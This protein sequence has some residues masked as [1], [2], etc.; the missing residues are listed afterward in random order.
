VATRPSCT[1]VA[2]NLCT[3]GLRHAHGAC[4]VPLIGRRCAA[5]SCAR[6]SAAGPYVRL[7]E[8][9]RLGL[10]PPVLDRMFDPFL[11]HYRG[12]RGPAWVCRGCCHPWRIWR[13]IDVGHGARPRHHL[14]ESGCPVSGEAAA[15][16]E[17]FDAQFAARRGAGRH[18]VADEKALVSLAEECGLARL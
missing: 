18:I 2:M 14:Y 11:H 8:R 13:A 9:H 16:V 5:R 10:P 1:M 6:Q 15:P 17:R 4:R 12:G 7:R 3:N